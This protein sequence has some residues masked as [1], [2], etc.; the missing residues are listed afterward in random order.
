MRERILEREQFIPAPIEA[1]CARFADIEN[2]EAITPPWLHFE[3]LSEQ[4]VVV[5]T[6]TI[7]EHRLRLHGIPIRW[8][9]L[10]ERWD[11][12]HGFTDTQVRGPYATWIHTHSFTPVDGGTLARDH[13]RYRIGYGPIGDL[14]LHLFV[15][16]DIERIFDYRRDAIHRLL[17]TGQEPGPLPGGSA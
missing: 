4:P 10:I 14:A 12:P 13:V 15:L 11:P 3:I 7:I 17:A 6:G 1:V 9:T 8:R 5:Q 16:R 2:L